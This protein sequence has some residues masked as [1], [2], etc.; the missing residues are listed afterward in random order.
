MTKKTLSDG[1]IRARN[2]IRTFLTYSADTFS[3]SELTYRGARS[4]VYLRDKLKE[5]DSDLGET[6]DGAPQNSLDYGAEM[7]EREIARDFPLLNSHTLIGLWGALEVCV[8][9]VATGRLMSD[10]GGAAREAISRLRVQLG[11]LLYLDTEERWEWILDQLKRDL[12][13]SLKTGVGQFESLLTAVGAGG[14]VDPKLRKTLHLVKAVRNL[15]AHRGGRVDAKFLADVPDTSLEIGTR[16]R[17]TSK[18]AASA[19]FAM[20]RYAD[21]LGERVGI[22]VGD[23]GYPEWMPTPDALL[24]DFSELLSSARSD[25]HHTPASTC[26]NDE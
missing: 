6:R 16:I 15:L 14:S 20:I 2:A 18:Q 1:E 24:K 19:N 26:D 7:A 3:V 25:E 22:R 13:S 21:L 8:D 4:Q 17:V 23:D 12:G 9:D 5:L 11:D 10:D